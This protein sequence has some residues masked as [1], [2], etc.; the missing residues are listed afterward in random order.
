MKMRYGV[1][2]A[3]CVVLTA[4]TAAAQQTCSTLGETVETL[5]ARDAATTMSVREHVVISHSRSGDEDH[6]TIEIYRPMNGTRLT[7]FRRVHRATT[8]TG[9]GSQTVEEI[10]ERSPAAPGESPK[11][12]QRSVTT[13]RRSGNGTMM[14]EREVFQR[15]VNDRLVLV[16]S[17][18]GDSAEN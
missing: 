10:E 12:I 7:L 3:F 1:V 4:A 6:V 2:A 9:D 5:R 17:E 11:L 14:R 16:C 15:D 18:T 8:T 13:V